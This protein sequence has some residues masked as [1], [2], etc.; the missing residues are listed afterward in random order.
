LLRLELGAATGESSSKPVTGTQA[1][2]T[3]GG[4]PAVVERHRG[5]GPGYVMRARKIAA[6][7]AGLLLIARIHAAEVLV[8]HPIQS[9]AQG[10]VMPPFDLDPSKVFPRENR[11]G[12]GG[13]GAKRAVIQTVCP[14]ACHLPP[15][16]NKTP[17]N[18]HL[19]RVAEV[20]RPIGRIGIL[21]SVAVCVGANGHPT[22]PPRSAFATTTTGVYVAKAFMNLKPLTPIGTLLSGISGVGVTHAA[23]RRPPC[24]K[25]HVK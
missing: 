6:A 1:S 13:F 5:T 17:W 23:I 9:D 24:S 2:V 18:A 25:D 3:G 11:V 21:G 14:T 8:D 16:P 10:K 4:V 7:I 20:R 12:R 15:R 19:H 22:F